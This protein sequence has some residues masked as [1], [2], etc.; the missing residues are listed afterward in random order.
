MQGTAVDG[1]RAEIALPVAQQRERAAV[2]AGGLG[3]L[4][5]EWA[6]FVDFAA[7]L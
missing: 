7:G 1:L 5:G 2:G 4:V 6:A 3:E